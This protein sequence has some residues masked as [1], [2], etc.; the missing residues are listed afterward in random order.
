[1]LLLLGAGRTRKGGIMTS[2]QIS[3]VT[4]HISP[5]ILLE[6]CLALCATT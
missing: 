4:L 1:M 6:Y 2:C 5:C 3:S